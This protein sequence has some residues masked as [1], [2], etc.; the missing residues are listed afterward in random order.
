[1]QS[2]AIADQFF[3]VGMYVEAY[4]YYLNA[5][6]IADKTLKTNFETIALEKVHKF[7]EYS[8]YSDAC[9][10]LRAY[11]KKLGYTVGYSIGP[12]GYPNISIEEQ[13]LVVIVKDYKI[14]CEILP[15]EGVITGT[16]VALKSI[17]SYIF[18]NMVESKT[19]LDI[20]FGRG[21][22]GL[23]VK[24][25]PSTAHWNIDGIDGFIRTCSNVDLFEKRIYRNIWH[26]LAQ[27]LTSMQLASY[28]VL[29]LFDVIEHLKVEEATDLLRLLL[30]SLGE[31]SRLV[32][33]TPLWFMPQGHDVEGDLEVHEFGV[34][35][36]SMF[37]LH[38]TM[39]HVEPDFLVGTFVYEKSSSKYIEKFKPLNDPFFDFSAGLK[40]LI[41]SGHK[42]DRILYFNS[43]VI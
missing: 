37:D 20:G 8:K 34:P 10:L 15:Y 25:N 12:Y 41:F 18:P 17:I 36:S 40:N 6:D 28:D 27:D 2:I 42:A 23:M 33:S 39:F 32:I 31:G 11:L 35:A 21:E 13:K 24:N 22:L 9:D 1:V 26:G 5:H 19:L 14:C 43:S 16:S 4:K 30:T 38:P 29:C 7:E 3:N